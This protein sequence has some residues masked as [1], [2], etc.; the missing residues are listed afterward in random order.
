MLFN[1]LY[2]LSDQFA[3][4][5]VFRYLTFR[6]GGAVITA[7]VLSF[8]FG[9]VLIRTLRTRQN[10]GQPDQQNTEN[11]QRRPCRGDVATEFTWTDPTPYRGRR[12]EADD[13]DV[14][15]HATAFVHQQ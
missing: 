9:P 15:R 12:I 3:V 8:V 14:R 4:L 1:F 10:G 13:W 7:L 6:T 5:N 2:P 11:R